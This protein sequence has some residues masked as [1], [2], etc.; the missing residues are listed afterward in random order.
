MDAVINVGN[1]PEAIRRLN[2]HAERDRGDFD[3]RFRN[4]HI[5]LLNETVGRTIF[6]KNDL[7]VDAS[8]L[9]E[10]MLPVGGQGSHH[11]HG[12]R[13]SEIVESLNRLDRP[14]LICKSY[15]DR[16]VLGVH[17]KKPSERLLAMVID[18]SASKKYD[19]LDKINK[20]ITIVP[21]DNLHGLLRGKDRADIIYLA[22][23]KMLGET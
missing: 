7:Y 14:D 20:L 9:Y 4:V 13:P 21:K 8:T 23:P 18:P 6:R 5:C 2:H 12:L 17:I 16:L 1:K 15:L 10:L 22:N 3:V 19:V 11:Y